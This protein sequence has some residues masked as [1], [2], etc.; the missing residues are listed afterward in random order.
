[1]STH[2]PFHP[3]R[4]GLKP[5]SRRAA[6][7]LGL[8]GAASLVLAPLVAACAAPAPASTPTQ[9][10]TN[11]P[12]ATR[13]PVATNTPFP[14]ST[15]TLAIAPT[16]TITPTPENTP[17]AS[18]SGKR[19]A[20]SKTFTTKDGRKIGYLEAGK[21]DGIPVI[22]FHGSP[23]C[24]LLYDPWVADAEKH[25]IRLI[26]YDR[27]GYG[28]SS[29][30]IG[31]NTAQC[32]EDVAA[33]AKELGLGKYY[34]WGISAGGPHVLACA[35][36]LPDQVIAAVAMTSLAP[37][38]AE[39]LNWWDGMSSDTTYEFKLA[40]QG[41]DGLGDFLSK[42]PPY[43]ATT[44][45]QSY[46]NEVGLSGAEANA[47]T[48]DMSDFFLD[49]NR[50]GTRQ[51]TEGMVEDD[52]TEVTPWGFELSQ[53][54]IPVLIMQGEKDGFV[55]FGH[56]QWLAKNI[57]HAA[58]KFIPGEGHIGMFNHIPEVHE[59]LLSKMK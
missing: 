6:L 43:Y 24:R 59:W 53:I 3:R 32:V 17:A 27:P 37:I 28:L 15:P 57:P 14:S 34:V 58:S 1:M 51:G 46:F 41:R 19:L 39:G 56:G 45:P 9:V 42:F 18:S 21:P 50:E 13:A 47:W 55:P 54:Q 2:T 30:L 35:A 22:E 49:Y 10:P 44:N 16:E 11:T 5:I 48:R 33:L 38:D 26:G 4:S 8:A 36:L 52:Q 12:E 7:R 25:G 29:P 40:R 20:I 23:G 31:R